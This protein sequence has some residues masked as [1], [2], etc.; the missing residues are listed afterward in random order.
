MEGDLAGEKAEDRLVDRDPLQPNARWFECIMQNPCHLM[1]L[2]RHRAALLSQRSDNQ[3]DRLMRSPQPY[4]GRRPGKGASAIRKNYCGKFQAGEGLTN[5]R[6]WLIGVCAH[7]TRGDI[8]LAIARQQGK[9]APSKPA[10]AMVN[11]P[12]Q[13]QH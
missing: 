6:L 12:G 2:D 9:P 7:A 8:V 4:S 5:A 13:A 1:Q 11:I 3:L 10:V